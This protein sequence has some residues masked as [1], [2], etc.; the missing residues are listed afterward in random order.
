MMKVEI[1]TREQIQKFA[2]SLIERGIDSSYFSFSNS[3]TNFGFSSYLYVGPFKVRCSD[4]SVS[5]P[6]RILDEMH[7]H[8]ITIDSHL[9]EIERHYFPERFEK[10]INLEFGSQQ[11]ANE[12]KIMGL[13]NSGIEFKYIQKDYR[14]STKG[15]HISMIA[16][17]NKVVIEFIRK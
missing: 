14:I 1:N 16:V 4:H 15:S 3:E 2:D 10:I 5:T 11:E 17:K 8:E 7:L 13:I 12:N 9:D 6:H